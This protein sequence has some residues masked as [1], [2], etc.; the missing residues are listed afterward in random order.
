MNAIP[1][2]KGRPATGAGIPVQVRLQKDELAAL[3]A[4][5]ARQNGPQPTRPAAI[6]SLMRVALTAAR[7]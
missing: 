7:D 4:F 3:D 5:I 1:K 2:K 6:R